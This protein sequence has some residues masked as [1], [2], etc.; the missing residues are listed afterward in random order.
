MKFIDDIVVDE[1]APL[2]L[3]VNNYVFKFEIGIKNLC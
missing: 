3:F 2:L 1:S